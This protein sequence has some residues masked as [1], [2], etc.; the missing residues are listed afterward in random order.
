MQREES[1][2]NTCS[3]MLLSDPKRCNSI[4]RILTLLVLPDLHKDQNQFIWDIL[5]LF[6]F[7]FVRT[8]SLDFFKI[9]FIF[10]KT[11]LQQFQTLRGQ[12]AAVLKLNSIPKFPFLKLWNN[13]GIIRTKRVMTNFSLIYENH[14]A[15]I[16]SIFYR[17]ANLFNK[18]TKQR[19]SKLSEEK[20]VKMPDRKPRL[21]ILILII[22]EMK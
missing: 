22:T 16:N 13:T 19:K 2:L 20:L 17:T 3:V 15:S 7:I 8:K 12:E 21:F 14:Y 10:F 1:N 9:C 18:Q 6:I 4:Q 5:L 11:F